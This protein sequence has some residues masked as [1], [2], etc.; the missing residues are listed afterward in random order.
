MTT[1]VRAAHAFHQLSD[2][3]LDRCRARAAVYD[4][5]NRF[6]TE[7]F[8]E[9]ADAGYLRAALPV[10]FGGAGAS[11]ADVVRA[12]R[13]LAA[14]AP[15]TALALTM[16]LYMTGA[17]ADLYRTGDR[18]VASILEEAAAGHVFAA[19]HAE[20]GNDVPV[21]LSTARAEP[22]SGGYRVTGRK[23]F[24]SLG[25]V[26]TRL[27]IHALVATTPD[28]PKVIHGFVRRDAEGVHVQDHWDA[29]GMRATQSFDTV[30]DGVFVPDDH[31]VRV[32]PAGDPNDRWFGTMS[33]WAFL[34][35]GG[36]YLGIADRAVEL[37]VE[38]ARTK[39]SIAIPRGAMA[40][41]PEIQH[42]VAQMYFDRLTAGTLLDTS[43]DDWAAGKAHADWPARILAVKKVAT[44]AAKAVVE[45]AQE[46]AG[47]AAIA[48]GHELERLYRD[49]RCGWFN[50]VNG[51]L[52]TEL[53]GKGVL[54][55]EP[56][57][58]W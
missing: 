42:A 27:G 28:G 20:N 25:P 45:R 6:F 57:P 11:V 13:R 22:V 7:D 30:L 5:E 14:A 23:R 54:G 3:V 2:D 38:S 44:D 19:G 55:I 51:F 24:G 18:S 8:D 31:V 16:H 29:L 56:Q 53:I 47:G 12:Q 35:F 58:R 34:Q 37:A 10:E 26:W 15:P 32:L 33:A 52:T 9:L 36:V 43:A 41:N 4:R 17:A 48:T 1:Q 21:L 40:Y 46:V 50:G 49:V 39:S